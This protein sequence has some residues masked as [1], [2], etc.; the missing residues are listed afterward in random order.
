MLRF[1]I[2]TF[3][4]ITVNINHGDSLFVILIVVNRV[5]DPPPLSIVACVLESSYQPFPRRTQDGGNRSG[6]RN[7]CLFQLFPMNFSSFFI[8]SPGY[9][10]YQIFYALMSLF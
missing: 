9:L 7:F 8:L 3:M 4:L 6:V 5:K 1:S 10:F 2:F